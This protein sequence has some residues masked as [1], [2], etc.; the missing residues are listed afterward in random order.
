MGARG[1]SQPHPIGDRD[2]FSDPISERESDPGADA[3][4]FHPDTHSDP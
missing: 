1:L 4:F 2:P 3:D